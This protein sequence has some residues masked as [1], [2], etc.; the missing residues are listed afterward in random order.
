MLVTNALVRELW[1]DG[2]SVLGVGYER[3][4]GSLEHLACG[5]LLLA[6]NGFGGNRA[7]VDS[8]LPEMRDAVFGGHAGNDG[9][10]IAWAR[11][12]RRCSWPTW[13]ATRAMA[14]GPCRRAR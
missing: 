13:A 5:T 8:L 2:G 9:S 12:A 4:D 3:P 7:M 14:P 6:C 10:A 11:A 1:T